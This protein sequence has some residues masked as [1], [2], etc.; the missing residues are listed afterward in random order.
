M[1]PYRLG[2]NES[3]A[4]SIEHQVRAVQARPRLLKAARF[5]NFKPDEDEFTFS[6]N[7]PMVVLLE[8]LQPLLY[9]EVIKQLANNGLAPLIKFGGAPSATAFRHL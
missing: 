8:S 6:L 4:K 2:G 9:T 3:F 1:E 5:Q 7:L